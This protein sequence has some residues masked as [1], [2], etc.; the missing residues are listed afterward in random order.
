MVSS[1]SAVLIGFIITVVVVG[2]SGAASLTIFLCIRFRDKYK[3]GTQTVAPVPASRQQ[4]RQHSR[5]RRI[6]TRRN[7]T[8]DG[9]GRLTGILQLMGN[10][11]KVNL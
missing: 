7:S 11:A 8:S 6:R 4:S 10:C 1:Q 3:R 2:L 5:R 9:S